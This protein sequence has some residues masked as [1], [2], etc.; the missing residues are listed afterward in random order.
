MSSTGTV[1]DE[2]LYP[3]APLTVAAT[4]V[5]S[6]S[7]TSSTAILYD[8]L[9]QSR[10]ACSGQGCRQWHP[11]LYPSRAAQDIGRVRRRGSLR[12]SDRLSCSHIR[13][14]RG[15]HLKCESLGQG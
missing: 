9:R 5:I 12:I 10:R 1:I 2:N 13:L 14:E 15:V 6:T 11:A 8:G 4:K 3:K 7:T